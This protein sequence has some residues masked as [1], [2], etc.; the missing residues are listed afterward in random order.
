MRIMID[1]KELVKRFNFE[2]NSLLDMTP[3]E[4]KLLKLMIMKDLE[5]ANEGK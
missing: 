1:I 2:V 5:K 3:F 4:F